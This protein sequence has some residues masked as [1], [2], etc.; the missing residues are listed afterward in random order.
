MKYYGAIKKPKILAFAIMWMEVEGIRL[1]EISI[2]IYIYICV[3]VCVC[4]CVFFP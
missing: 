2:S 4:V 3:C 1:N